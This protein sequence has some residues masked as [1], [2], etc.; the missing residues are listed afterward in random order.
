MS[1]LQLTDLLICQEIQ[2]VDTK[3]IKIRKYENIILKLQE[4]GKTM[5]ENV[6]HSISQTIELAI[7]SAFLQNPVIMK[8]IDGPVNS[9]EKKIIFSGMKRHP[10]AFEY[11][12]GS[13]L[14][15]IGLPTICR[16]E[17]KCPGILFII[18]YRDKYFLCINICVYEMLVLV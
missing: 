12:H 3:Q 15:A 10:S 8:Q 1:S 5:G 18:Y 11:V 14:D 13:L 16:K 4:I 7:N 6:L 9:L 2:P 17:W